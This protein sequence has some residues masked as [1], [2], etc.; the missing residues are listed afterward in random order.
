M[1]EVEDLKLDL[2]LEAYIGLSW[3]TGI[4]NLMWH[5]DRDLEGLKHRVGDWAT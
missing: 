4:P 2:K 1:S 3:A 5:E